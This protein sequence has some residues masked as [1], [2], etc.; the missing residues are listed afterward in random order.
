MS[1]FHLKRRLGSLSPSDNFSGGKML[2]SGELVS[3]QVDFRNF[4]NSASF[5]LKILVQFHGNSRGHGTHRHAPLAMRSLLPHAVM[6]NST[7][8]LFRVGSE[9]HKATSGNKCVDTNAQEAA[10]RLAVRV[11]SKRPAP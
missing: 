1:L 5:P 9:R 3:K 10:G 6:Y 11:Y 2:F 8:R 4:S 7:F